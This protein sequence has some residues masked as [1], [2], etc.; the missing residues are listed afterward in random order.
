MAYRWLSVRFHS[1][2]SIAV[3]SIRSKSMFMVSKKIYSKSAA[4]VLIA[5]T[6]K[7]YWPEK[8][9]LRQSKQKSKKLSAPCQ[10]C[11]VST[12][13]WML[14]PRRVIAQP[15]TMVISPQSYWQ[16]SQRM[17]VSKPH[18][19]KQWLITVWSI[20]WGAWRLPNK[21]IWLISLTTQLVLQ[22]W[23]CWPPSSMI[24]GWS[25]LKTILCMKIIWPILR[26][27]LLLT[28]M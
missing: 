4:W 14:V 5:L 23:Y 8:Y 25:W 3:L 7:C 15:F 27:C 24:E 19:S 9:Q 2:C 12:T 16:K 10:M 17:T 6:V 13:S 28:L 1:V 20:L 26:W 22:S 21:A 11:A 18:K